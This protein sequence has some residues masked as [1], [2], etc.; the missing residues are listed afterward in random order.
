M[1]ARTQQIFCLCLIAI[2][3]LHEAGFAQVLEGPLPELPNLPV[4]RLFDLGQTANSD[5]A[6]FATMWER[7]CDLPIG[8]ADVRHILKLEGRQDASQDEGLPAYFMWST[9]AQYPE[10]DP[11]VEWTGPKEIKVVIPTW[12]YEYHVTER[13]GRGL[14]LHIDFMPSVK[15]YSSEGY[16][17]RTGHSQI[18]RPGAPF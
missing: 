15:I 18:I 7:E 5:K 8:G 16:Y 3:C 6:A 11:I 1:F 17:G 13:V 12:T 14:T 10:H 4:C 2:F 9:D